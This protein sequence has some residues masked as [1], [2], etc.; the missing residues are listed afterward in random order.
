M[1]PAIKVMMFFVLVFIIGMVYNTLDSFGLTTLEEALTNT[2][3]PQNPYPTVTTVYNFLW[4]S[5]PI[6]GI[7]STAIYLALEGRGPSL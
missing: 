4:L 5:I 7:I 2:S 3:L 1:K 6:L